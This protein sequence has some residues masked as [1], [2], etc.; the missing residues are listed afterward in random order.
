MKKIILLT[1]LF[2]CFFVKLSNAQEGYV[3][4]QKNDTIKCDVRSWGYGGAKYK[5]AE[6]KTVK[7]YVNDFKEYRFTK[8]STIYRAKFL[9]GGKKQDFLALLENGKIC[10]YGYSINYGGALGN[11][12]QLYVIK[13]TDTTNKLSPIVIGGL[14]YDGPNRTERKKILFDMMSD[15]PKI[16]NAYKAEDTLNPDKVRKYVQMYNKAAAAK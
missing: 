8:D 4:T 9:F 14:G 1:F 16:A 3:I 15:E 7:I 11:Y 10:L 6:G 5:T 12:G 2:V 13:S